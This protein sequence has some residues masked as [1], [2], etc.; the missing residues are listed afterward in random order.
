MRPSEGNEKFKKI[1]LLKKLSWM[2]ISLI[3]GNFVKQW[4]IEVFR[5]VFE[6]WGFLWGDRLQEWCARMKR[7]ETRRR[8]MIWNEIWERVKKKNWKFSSR[9]MRKNY[10][11]VW[12]DS[13][14]KTDLPSAHLVRASYVY[15]L[16]APLSPHSTAM[17]F[18]FTSI[19]L[20]DTFLYYFLIPRSG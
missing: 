20:R 6:V 11:I 8:C 16:T 15:G 4:G 17:K 13:M 3:F 7:N 19:Y 2:K 18:N 1:V 9:L 5:E 14:L 10:S 12:R